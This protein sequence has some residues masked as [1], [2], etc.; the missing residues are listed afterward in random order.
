MLVRIRLWGHLGMGPGGN[1]KIS[2]PIYLPVNGDGGLDDHMGPLITVQIKCAI[3]PMV[4]S[5]QMHAKP[6]GSM[7][8]RVYGDGFQGYTFH[9]I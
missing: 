6:L 9:E 1:R 7:Q 3:D 5:I 2:P 4:Q 8:F